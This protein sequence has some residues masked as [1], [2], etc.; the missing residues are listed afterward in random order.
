MMKKSAIVVIVVVVPSIICGMNWRAEQES[1]I[2]H[3]DTLM[4]LGNANDTI[5][6]VVNENGDTVDWFMYWDGEK[7][8]RN[9]CDYLYKL[10]DSL[11]GE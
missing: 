4:F 2:H 11:K 8:D 1:E 10:A 6:F 3:F 7:L 5:Y 9:L